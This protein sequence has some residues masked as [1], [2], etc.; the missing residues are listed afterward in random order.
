MF[1]GF[2]PLRGSYLFAVCVFLDFA[3]CALVLRSSIGAGAG[4]LH[5][6]PVSGKKIMVSDF[7]GCDGKSSQPTFVE[8]KWKILFSKSCKFHGIVQDVEFGRVEVFIVRI[9]NIAMFSNRTWYRGKKDSKFA[10]HNTL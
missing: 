4:G 2:L 1:A 9:G 6:Q 5:V 10:V 3:C 8:R 7:E